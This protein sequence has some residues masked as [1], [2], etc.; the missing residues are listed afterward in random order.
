MENTDHTLLVGKGAERQAILA[1][2][3]QTQ[4]FNNNKLSNRLDRWS[5]ILIE[6]RWLNKL[7]S[8]WIKDSTS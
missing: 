1:G 3:Y 6:Y 2:I 4:S 8:S 5:S 7:K